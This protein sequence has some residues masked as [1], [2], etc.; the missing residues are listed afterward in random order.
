MLNNFFTKEVKFSL[1]TENYLSLNKLIKEENP[2]S[3]LASLNKNLIK[4]YLE[5]SIKSDNLFFYICEYENKIIGYAILAR[6]PLFLISEFNVIKYSIFFNLLLNFKLK[7]IINIL[8]SMSKID[9]FFINKENKD[10][11]NKTFNLN[12]L[13]IDRKFQSKGIGKAF[14]R[15][16][17]EDLKKNNNLE[18]IT[19]ETFNKRAQSFYEN[20]LNF[21]YIGKKLRFF[22]NLIVYKKSLL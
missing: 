18:I 11:I 14:V 22:K 4:K 15:N 17:F 6:Q 9:L 16:I 19:V 13:A 21:H 7:T 5:I 20:K 12:L 1:S 10:I 8:L 3:I 2:D